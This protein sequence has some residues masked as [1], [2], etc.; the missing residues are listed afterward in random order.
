MRKLN[1]LE[2]W[3]TVTQVATQCNV[4]SQAIRDAIKAG[5]IEAWSVG[6]YMLI[7]KSEIPLFWKT[8]KVKWEAVSEGH[9]KRELVPTH[10]R[11]ADE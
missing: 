5:K 4:T 9:F 11:K 3:R 10:G 2:N 8:R 6:E 1:P 7:H